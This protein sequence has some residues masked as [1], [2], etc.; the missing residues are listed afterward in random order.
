[1]IYMFRPNEHWNYITEPVYLAL[2]RAGYGQD[3]LT[4]ARSK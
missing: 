4:C 1:M 3:R 2:L